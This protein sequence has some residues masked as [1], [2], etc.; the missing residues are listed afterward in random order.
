ME[1]DSPPPLP[2]PRICALV[3]DH[4]AGMGDLSGRG[5]WAVPRREDAAPFPHLE[6]LLIEG[7]LP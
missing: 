2:A 1:Q 3:T 5:S 6:L 7:L 4:S